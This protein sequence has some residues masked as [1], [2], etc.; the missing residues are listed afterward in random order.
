MKFHL[1][2]CDVKWIFISPK[3]IPF[4]QTFGSFPTEELNAA[5]RILFTTAFLQ[6]CDKDSLHQPE[7][8][9]IKTLLKLSV[10]LFIS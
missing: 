4:P 10:R 9:L 1:D 5:K 2:E 6:L 7:G 8:N 3:R